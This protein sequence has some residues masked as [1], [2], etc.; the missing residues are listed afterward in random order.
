MVLSDSVWKHIPSSG[1]STSARRGPRPAACG[2][3]RVRRPDVAVAR[4]FVFTNVRA[5]AQVGRRSPFACAPFDAESR[6]GARRLRRCARTARAGHGRWRCAARLKPSFV[7]RRSGGRAAARPDSLASSRGA[8]G[9]LALCGGARV[10]VAVVCSRARL[11]LGGCG[12][13]WAL[14]LC[15]EFSIEWSETTR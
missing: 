9:S 11:S 6:V 8:C 12:A 3:A 13:E 14:V 10:R 5:S 2:G 1:A 4:V 7:W 15:M